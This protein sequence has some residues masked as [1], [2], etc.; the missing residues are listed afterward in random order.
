MGVLKN[1]RH[2]VFARA[3]ADG[4]P[5]S[6]AYVHAGYP[7][8]RGNASR[9]NAREYIRQRV[10]E[11]LAPPVVQSSARLEREAVSKE[12][13]LAGLKEVA[14]RCMQRK[15]VIH[16]GKLVKYAFEPAA[17][18]RAFELLG[19]ELG[20]FVEQVRQDTNLRVIASEPVSEEDWEAKYARTIEHKPEEPSHGNDNAEAASIE[21]EPDQGARPDWDRAADGEEDAADEAA[22]AADEGGE[23]GGPEGGD[24]AGEGGEEAPSPGEADHDLTWS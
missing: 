23:D 20:M 7:P 17:A 9:L 14:D 13:V 21:A 3:I 4:K 16:K 12:W 8:N 10:A 5:V 22:E 6:Q 1:A 24:G 2:E 19:R 18:N 15:A 11:I